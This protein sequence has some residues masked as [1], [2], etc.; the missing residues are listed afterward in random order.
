[1][2]LIG[3]IRRDFIF[4]KLEGCINVFICF[5]NNIVIYFFFDVYICFIIY[6]RNVVMINNKMVENR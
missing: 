4:C 5:R 1:M 2:V 3:K 6:I